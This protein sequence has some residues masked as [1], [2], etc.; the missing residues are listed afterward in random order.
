MTNYLYGTKKINS[1]HLTTKFLG[2]YAYR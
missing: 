1:L 2:A